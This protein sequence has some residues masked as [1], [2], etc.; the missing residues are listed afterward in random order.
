MQV[1]QFLEAVFRFVAEGQRELPRQI[2]E[3][4]Q[5][6]VDCR[7]FHS[8][9]DLVTELLD[10]RRDVAKR[11]QNRLNLAGEDRVDHVEVGVQIGHLPTPNLR[12]R[13]P[14]V[15]VDVCINRRE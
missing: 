3:C 10:V 14:E 8:V 11:A 6:L 12:R 4:L 5:Q 1:D 15:E 9:G 7:H 13:D 2:A